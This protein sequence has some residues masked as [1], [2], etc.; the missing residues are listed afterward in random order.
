MSKVDAQQEVFAEWASWRTRQGITTPPDDA[1]AAKF[2]HYLESEMP[3]LLTFEHSS[4][5][6]WRAVH[7]WLLSAHLL[8]D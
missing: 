3:R 4:D 7:R 6:R 1:E 2:F 8:A 5:E